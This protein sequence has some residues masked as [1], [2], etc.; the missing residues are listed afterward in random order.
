M[1]KHK[2][3]D[4][5]FIFKKV[6]HIKY[7]KID[8]IVG[9]IGNGITEPKWAKTV[10]DKLVVIKLMDNPEGPLVLFNEYLCYRLA[11]LIGL[12]MPKSGVA[13]FNGDFCFYSAAL[14]KVTILNHAIMRSISNLN[15]FYS[16]I[17]FDHIISNKDRNI[18]N[19][20]V[21]YYKNRIT[22]F[23]IDHTHV[24]VNGAIWD[25][26]CLKRSELQKDYLDTD[27][28]CMNN[29]LY[30]CF[31]QNI[32]YDNGEFKKLIPIFS[33][34]ITEKKI[35]EIISEIPIEW[36][37]KNDDVEALIHY[38]IY[39]INHLNELCSTIDRY[40]NERR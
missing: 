20:L 37:P 35:R 32:D 38:I 17:L 19:L 8:S 36:L 28:L 34:A 10:D 31:F 7:V 4:T 40:V 33:Q 14:P 11:I 39:R 12:P 25:S 27:I 9:N 21:Q 5:L 22:L 18:G 29:V 26:S 3:Y 1:N 15:V 30:D 6:I 13:T 24:F 23:V 2:K 16:I